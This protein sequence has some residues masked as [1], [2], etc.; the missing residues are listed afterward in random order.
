MNATRLLPALAAIALTACAAGPDYTTPELPT[1]ASWASASDAFPTT[2]ATAPWWRSLACPALD[3]LVDEALAANHDL[4]MAAARIQQARA[5]AGA[6]DGADQPQLDATTGYTRTRTTEATPSPIGGRSYNTWTLGFDVRWELD[7]FGRLARETEAR[8]AEVELAEADRRGIRQSLIAE[9]VTAYADL[10]GARHRREVAE[11]SIRAADELLVITRARAETGIG[12]ELDTARAERLLASARAR[13][14]AHEQQWRRS[15]HRL[16]LLVG[17]SPG[18]LQASLR[19]TPDLGAVPDLIATG[20]PADLVRQRPDVRI[21]ERRLAAATARLGS[22]LAERYPRL[23]LAGF[24]G[25]EADRTGDLFR[26][27]SRAMRAGP[28]LQLPL[29]TGGTV[30]EQIAVRE[31]QIDEARAELEQTVLRAF[32][33][34]ENGLVG[35]QQERLRLGELDRAVTA[36][37]RARALAQQRFDA[38]IDDF[39]TVLDAEQGRLDL[40]DERASAATAVLRQFA[41]LHKALGSDDHAAGAN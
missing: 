34:V 9:L 3:Q 18:E 29:F 36:A 16:A 5:L 14:P 4:R 2:P 8:T 15:A 20:L 27:S 40:A 28:S 7:L 38:G 33:E 30:G 37:E 25:L 31:A 23:S 19:A 39:L 22:A 41:L 13:L 26:S 1:P 21:A 24:F 12:T 11:A 17:K 10:H 32:E 35:L 6:A